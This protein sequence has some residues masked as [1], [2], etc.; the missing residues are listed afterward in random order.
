VIA[1]LGCE[2]TERG[3]V[4]AGTD[5]QTTVPGEFACGDA[6]RGQSLVVWA[7]REGREAARGVDAYL[8]G[9]TFLQASPE[10]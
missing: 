7:I 5:Y 10:L 8:M 4:K 3:T 1:Q 9:E 2:L 6:R